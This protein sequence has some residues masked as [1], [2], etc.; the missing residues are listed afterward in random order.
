MTNLRTDV[1][2]SLITVYFYYYFS[3]KHP[4]WRWTHRTSCTLGTEAVFVG[5]KSRNVKPLFHVSLWDSGRMEL[6]LCFS[7]RLHGFCMLF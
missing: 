2:S 1:T 3:P 6:Y 4:A 5:L 7:L